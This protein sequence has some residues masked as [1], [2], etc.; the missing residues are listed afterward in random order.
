MDGTLTPNEALRRAVE[1]A[2]GQSALA[3]LI[4]RSQQAISDR[5]GGDQS[6]WAEDVLKVELETGVPRWQLRPDLYP[7]E[8]Y[9]LLA[10]MRAGDAA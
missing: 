3:R 1:L 2:G 5:V 4:G 6:L 8:E 9:A 10:A 7:P